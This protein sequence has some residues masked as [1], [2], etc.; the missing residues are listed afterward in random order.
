[1][2]TR[3][4]FGADSE[5]CSVSSQ[6]T[7]LARASPRIHHAEQSYSSRQ[8][9]PAPAHLTH[10][11]QVRVDQGYERK[12]PSEEAR[13]AHVEVAVPL[14]WPQTHPQSEDVIGVPPT[15]TGAPLACHTA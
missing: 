9:I 13:T 10:L 12:R 11:T 7:I 8:S 6:A 15:L 1:M 14:L 5:V 3:Q 4:P 2:R